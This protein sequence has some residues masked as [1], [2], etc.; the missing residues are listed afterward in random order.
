[1]GSICLN[2]CVLKKYQETALT[3]KQNEAWAG[4][5]LKKGSWAPLRCPVNHLEVTWNNLI[6]RAVSCGRIVSSTNAG[7]LG[8]AAERAVRGTTLVSVLTLSDKMR[9]AL[10][11]TTLTIGNLWEPQNP[12]LSV[13]QLLFPRWIDLWSFR[14]WGQLLTASDTKQGADHAR[15]GLLQ[16]TSTYILTQYDFIDICIHN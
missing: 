9:N 5:G 11:S 2:V 10:R 1:M 6:T 4:F 8:K 13:L 3:I 14:T 15:A 7:L 16:A 12:K